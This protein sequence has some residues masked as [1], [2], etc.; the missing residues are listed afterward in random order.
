MT[1]AVS[2]PQADEDSREREFHFTE[3]DF[4]AVCRYIGEHAGIVLSEAKRDMVY[5]RL[6]RRLRAL[7][8]NRFA[9]YLHLLDRDPDELG[10]F[11]NALTTNLTAFFREEHHFEFLAR[12]LVPA[13]AADRNRTRLRI[14]SA[15]CST[16]EEPYSLAMTLAEALPADRDW[17]LRILATDLDTEV[18]ARAAQGVY[19]GERL[20][21][22]RE[23]RRRRWFLRGRGAHAGQV[24]VA[25][26][27]QDMITFRQ[28]NLL[29]EWPFQGP[30]DV[31]FCRNVVIYFDKSTQ[32]VLFDRYADL[33]TAHGHLFIGHSETLFRVSERFDS[34]GNTIYRK[35][36]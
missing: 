6:A 7:D 29:Q 16:G 21:G 10:Q 23:E 2:Q 11:V 22:V 28:L 9:D 32:R 20:K 34:L 17:D 18:L 30:F 36:Q 26:E 25:P 27:L 1:R 3:D 8:L 31:I 5:S 12:T 13:W 19:S 4:R 24:R 33:L 35:R 14:W 15:G